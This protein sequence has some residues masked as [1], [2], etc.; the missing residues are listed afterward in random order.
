MSR[1]P[2]VAQTSESARNV[3]HG[4]RKTK[5]QTIG[6]DSSDIMFKSSVKRVETDAVWLYTIDILYEHCL[7]RKI[8]SS[9]S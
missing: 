7:D 8:L 6:G 4:F 5:G 3:I 2:S 9:M 1:S